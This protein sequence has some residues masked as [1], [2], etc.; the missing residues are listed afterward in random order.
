MKKI[1]TALLLSVILLMTSCCCSGPRY[2][3]NYKLTYKVHYPTDVV[4]YTYNFMGD[5]NAH[6]YLRSDRGTNYII[7]VHDGEIDNPW[8]HWTKSVCYTTAPI[9][10]VSVEKVY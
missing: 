7:V 5:N 1:L 6:V 10:I 9:E 4:E 3:V 8:S 2:N